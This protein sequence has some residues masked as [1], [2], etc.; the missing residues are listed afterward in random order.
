MSINLN[1]LVDMEQITVLCLG[2]F[3]ND[4]KEELE[5]GDKEDASEVLRLI[6]A[7]ETIFKELMR[8]EEYFLWKLS[9]GFDIH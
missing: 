5:H 1:D 2:Q 7:L 4:L 6:I 8:P 9:S 3:H